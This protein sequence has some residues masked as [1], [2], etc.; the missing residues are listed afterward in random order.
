MLYSISVET[1]HTDGATGMPVTVRVALPAGTKYKAA[2]ALAERAYHDN[3]A[4]SVAV[5]LIT[6]DRAGRIMDVFSGRWDSDYDLQQDD[7][8]KPGSLEG[9]YQVY[10]KCATELGWRIKSFDE[11]SRS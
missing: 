11:W 7:E 8:P 2:V 6:G 4:V 1:A 10:V 3:R 9:R 5:M